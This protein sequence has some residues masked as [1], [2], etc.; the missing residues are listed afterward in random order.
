MDFNS[1]QT[2]GLRGSARRNKKISRVIEILKFQ[3]GDQL[4]WSEK[5]KT[6]QFNARIYM[7]QWILSS[8]EWL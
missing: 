2:T 4:L 7:L 8:S 5:T 6:K 3:Y 1:R